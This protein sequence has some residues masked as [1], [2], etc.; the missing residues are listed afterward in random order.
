MDSL[1][2]LIAPIGIKTDHV[3]TWLREVSA[4]ANVL[5]LIHSEKSPKYDFPAIARKLER[6]I[7]KANKHIKIQKKIIK[8]P[9]SLEPTYDVITEIIALEEKKNDELILKDGKALPLIRKDFILNIT[10]GTNAMAAATFLA[11]TEWGT[12]AHYIIEPQ[13][14]DAPDKKYVVDLAI[15]P[16]AS[17]K[18]N[19]SQKKVLEFIANNEYTIDNTPVGLEVNPII[20]QIT[21]KNLLKKMGWPIEK[22]SNLSEIIKELKKKGMVSSVKYTEHYILPNGKKLVVGSKL[23]TDTKSPSVEYKEFEYTRYVA[24]PLQIGKNEGESTHKIT[25]LGKQVSRHAKM[26]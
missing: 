16:V 13:E 18:M 22:K 24:W 5:W 26:Y 11:A 6:D 4:D 7:K 17:A 3:L 14:G 9:F 10:G 25:A 15:R 8:D 20:G 2:I 1:A 21:N 12:R 19:Q 23:N